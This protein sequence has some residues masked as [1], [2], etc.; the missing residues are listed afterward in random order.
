MTGKLIIAGCLL[1]SAIWGAV[2]YKD[3]LQYEE[4][5]EVERKFLASCKADGK[6]DYYCQYLWAETDR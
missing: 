2:W 1:I 5:Q 4:H 3:S 6:P